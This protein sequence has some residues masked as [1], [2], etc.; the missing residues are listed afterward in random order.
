MQLNADGIYGQVEH[1]GADWLYRNHVSSPSR[2]RTMMP[3]VRDIFGVVL[4]IITAFSQV[5][6][7]Y[8]GR[9]VSP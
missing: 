5:V 6:T 1:S 3:I 7:Y 9:M 8:G 4:S 2:S